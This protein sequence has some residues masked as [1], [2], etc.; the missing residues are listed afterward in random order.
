MAPTETAGPPPGQPQPFPPEGDL[1]HHPPPR[2]RL[3]QSCSAQVVL[4]HATHTLGRQQG[5]PQLP[6]PSPSRCLAITGP[7]RP[8][9]PSSTP[10]QA[11]GSSPAMHQTT[12]LVRGQTEP[13]LCM[14]IRHGYAG[15]AAAAGRRQTLHGDGHET[16]DITLPGTPSLMPPRPDHSLPSIYCK[17]TGGSRKGVQL[18]QKKIQKFLHGTYRDGRPTTPWTAPALPARGGPLPPSPSP[19]QAQGSRP[20][21]TH[22][23]PTARGSPTPQAISQPMPCYHWKQLRKQPTPTPT[24]LCQETG[25]MHGNTRGD[26]LN[27]P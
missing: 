3:R 17:P 20:R 23:G 26:R 21:H 19:G 6:R 18:L 24:G 10:G 5:A 7:W 12:G 4:A 27:S 1:C 8:L 2:G 9:P 13:T 25:D 11:Q 22:P 14:D 16:T 15:P